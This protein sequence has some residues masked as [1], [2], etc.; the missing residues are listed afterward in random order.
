[1]ADGEESAPYFWRIVIEE[2]GAEYASGQGTETSAREAARLLAL[3]L[4]EFYLHKFP[5]ENGHTITIKTIFER[6]AQ[7]D[8]SKARH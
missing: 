2:D 3:W 4:H 1:M 5:K 8:D 6:L 7:F